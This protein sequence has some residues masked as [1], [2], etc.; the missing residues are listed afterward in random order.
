MRRCGECA[1]WGNPAGLTKMA[2]VRGGEMK[3]GGAK[4][5]GGLVCV[6]RK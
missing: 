3:S 1:G 6:Q 4:M 2:G 5:A